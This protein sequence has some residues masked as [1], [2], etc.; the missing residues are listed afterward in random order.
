MAK[1]PF[2]VKMFVTPC[3]KKCPS[4]SFFDM[5]LYLKCSVLRFNIKDIKILLDLFIIIKNEKGRYQERK[6][7][8]RSKAIMF[9]VLG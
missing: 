2:S 3:L 7:N 8:V 5:A 1:K 6:Y 4:V 9:T